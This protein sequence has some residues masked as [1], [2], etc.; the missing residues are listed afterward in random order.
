MI[1]KI[2]N[3]WKRIAAKIAHFQGHLILGVIYLL[4]LAPIACLFR[5]F[6]QDPLTCS[7]KSKSS[8]WHKR[9]PFTSAAEFLRRMY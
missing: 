8:Y 4:I 9:H 2:W 1:N 5:L 6:G 3:G 7:E